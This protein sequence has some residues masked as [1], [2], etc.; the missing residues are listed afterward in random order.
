MTANLGEVQNEAGFNVCLMR[1]V[2]NRMRGCPAE[3]RWR[4]LS[5][6]ALKGN[7]PRARLVEKTPGRSSREQ[8]VRTHGKRGD[9]T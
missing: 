6:Y 5:G 4:S 8:G 9:A 2:A 7:A 1:S 3:R